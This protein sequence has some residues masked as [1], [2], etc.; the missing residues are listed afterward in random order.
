[1]AVKTNRFEARLTADERERIEQAASAAGV[2]VSAFVVG[3]AVERAEEIIAATTTTVA[4]AD[5][6][7]GLLTALDEPEPAPRLRKAAKRSRRASRIAARRPTGSSLLATTTSVRS[8]AAMRNWTSGYAVTH[9]RPPGRAPAPTAWW[10]AKARS[11]A[12]SRWR[13]TSWCATKRRLGLPV[14]L[15]NRSRRSC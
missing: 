8:P 12:T 4:P 11:S 10:T 7:D 3:V 1:M 6:F 2:S 14:L 9:A 15:P 13:P 5:Y